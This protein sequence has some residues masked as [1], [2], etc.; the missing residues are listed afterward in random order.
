MCVTRP[1]L[2]EFQL[3]KQ[4]FI[5]DFNYNNSL[6]LFQLRG[7]LSA[8]QMQYSNTMYNTAN[9]LY[10]AVDI[11]NIVSTILTINRDIERFIRLECPCLQVTL[12]VSI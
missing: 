4:S 8:I 12:E 2:I 9:V 5:S 10:A 6:N 7:T 11:A 1:L 3:F